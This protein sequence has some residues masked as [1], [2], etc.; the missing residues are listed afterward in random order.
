MAECPVKMDPATRSATA[1]PR[2]ASLNRREFAVLALLCE[3]GGA[4]DPQAVLLRGA[5]GPHTPLANLR[6]AIRQ[7]RRKLEDDPEVPSLIVAVPGEGYRLRTAVC[8]RTA[9]G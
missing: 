8:L 9:A 3:V 2:S 7:L 4:V 5:L 6:V 1:G